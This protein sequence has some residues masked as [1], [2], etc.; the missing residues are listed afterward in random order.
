VGNPTALPGGLPE[1]DIES[2][3]EFQ[4]AM[5][6]TA[7]GTVSVGTVLDGKWVVLE[8]IGRG[9]MERFA[10]CIS[11]SSSA[12]LPSRLSLARGSKQRK[13]PSGARKGK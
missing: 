12:M 4:E 2:L 7:A 9:G 10:G 11:A 6:E 5:T 1:F 3:E 8:F 13:S